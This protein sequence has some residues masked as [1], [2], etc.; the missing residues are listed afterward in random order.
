MTR[1]ICSVLSAAGTKPWD[2]SA[3]VLGL[4][5]EP[6]AGHKVQFDG[7]TLKNRS[8]KGKQAKVAMVAWNTPAELYIKW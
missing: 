4:A 8:I 7:K 6:S 5:E 2:L 3:S 1:N